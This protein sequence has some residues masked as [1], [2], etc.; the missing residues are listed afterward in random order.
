M[1]IDKYH[2]VEHR[3]YMSNNLKR[4]TEFGELLT[5]EEASK[6]IGADTANRTRD[7]LITNQLLYQLSYAGYFLCLQQGDI[8][9]IYLIKARITDRYDSRQP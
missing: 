5:T 1:N 2:E 8:V 9:G 3:P 6:I 7:L 4:Y